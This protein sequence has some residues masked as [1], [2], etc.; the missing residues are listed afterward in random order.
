MPKP[1]TITKEINING[2]NK[3]LRRVQS[4][5]LLYKK[6]FLLTTNIFKNRAR[7]L[8]DRINNN[9]NHLTFNHD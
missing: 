7:V 2:N 1:S 3:R 4:T 6:D 9:C 5:H 8:F